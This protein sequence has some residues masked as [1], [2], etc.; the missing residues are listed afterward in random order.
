[1][2]EDVCSENEDHDADSSLRDSGK[3]VDSDTTSVD[4]VFVQV[5]ECA[6]SEPT[7]LPEE[8]YAKGEFLTCDPQ[9]NK[10]EI[11]KAQIDALAALTKQEK[12]MIGD[13]SQGDRAAQGDYVRNELSNNILSMN[14]Q[15][16]HESKQGNYP[17]NSS[18][19]SHGQEAN[20]SEENSSLV[21]GDVRKAVLYD[22]QN[23]GHEG[24]NLFGKAGKEMKESGLFDNDDFLS[25]SSMSNLLL[26]AGNSQL[27]PSYLNVAR[28]FPGGLCA[29]SIIQAGFLSQ[30]DVVRL[31]ESL[32]DRQGNTCL[33]R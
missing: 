16:I 27:L 25:K 10:E 15:S 26:L 22:G 21:Q 8:G 32:I 31:S 30:A 18:P 17:C 12:G 7:S 23:G 29:K 5:H 6:A 24:R 28:S 4:D 19:I 14:G 1:M 2:A 11:S 9:D 13:R 33:V 3:P 20:S